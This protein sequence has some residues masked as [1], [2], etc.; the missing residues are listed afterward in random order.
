MLYKGSRSEKQPKIN[1]KLFFEN[2]QQQLFNHFQPTRKKQEIKEKEKTLLI[3]DIK[4]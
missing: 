3:M 4:D 2:P 1:F